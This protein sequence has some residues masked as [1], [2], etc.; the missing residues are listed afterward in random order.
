MDTQASFFP[1]S[2]SLTAAAGR[3]AAG[4]QGELQT[5]ATEHGGTLLKW[6]LARSGQASDAWDLVQDAFERALAKRP[7]LSGPGH[8]RRWLLAVMKNRHVDQQR[9]RAIQNVADV[10]IDALP[11]LER[12]EV[13]LWRRVDMNAVTTAVSR[14]PALLREPLVLRMAGHPSHV[15]AERLSLKPATVAS[16]MFRARRHIQRTLEEGL[17]TSEN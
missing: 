16:R 14:L 3:V 9:A 10:D 1:Q 12:R 2:A 15:I 6:A 17:A 13:A 8:L 4:A 7:H 5:M 11:D